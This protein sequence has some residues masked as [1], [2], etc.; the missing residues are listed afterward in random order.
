MQE[1]PHRYLAAAVLR[2][3]AHVAL[4]SPGLADLESAPPAE[5]GGPGDR[6]SPET[7]LVAAVA[8]CFVLTFKGI[9]RASKVDWLAVQCDV[10][11]VLDREDGI[12]QFVQFRVKAI[13]D[14]PQGADEARVRRLIEKA[15]QGCLITNSMN[16]RVTLDGEIRV[17]G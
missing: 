2:P 12:T 7:L 1:L 14:V 15:E 16:A 11:G 10:E 13:V 8:D 9:A 5:Y 4:S 3:E 17:T 6:W